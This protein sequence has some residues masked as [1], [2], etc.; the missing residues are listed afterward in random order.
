MKHGVLSFLV[1]AGLLLGWSDVRADV[2]AYTS[3][4][5]G[6][7]PA[8]WHTSVQA[9]NDECGYISSTSL[10]ST[11]GSHPSRSCTTYGIGGD[12]VGHW[13][14]PSSCTLDAVQY[15]KLYCAS[16]FVAM[17]SGSKF[18]GCL[19]ACPAGYSGGTTG[20]CCPAGT[21]Y[22]PSTGQCGVP[23]PPPCEAGVVV[24]GHAADT[25]P[26]CL[27]GCSFA[28]SAPTV[29]F[30]GTV[31]AISGVHSRWIGA[32]SACSDG[33]TLVQGATC[34]EMT[35]GI[36]GGEDPNYRLIYCGIQAPCP[37]GTFAFAGLCATDTSN[38]A[39]VIIDGEEVC[40]EAEQNCVVVNGKRV[41]A[42]LPDPSATETYKDNGCVWSFAAGE[43]VC[44]TD[45]AKTE[46]SSTTTTVTDPVTGNTTKTTVTTQ[47]DNL[48]PG[49]TTTTTTTVYDS[50]GNELSSDS[51]SKSTGSGGQG[52]ALIV[53]APSALGDKLDLEWLRTAE[54]V[55]E[56]WE[57]RWAN[58]PVVAAL[59]SF[60]DLQ[61]VAGQ[62]VC[63]ELCLPLWGETLC[64]TAHCD[65]WED[66]SVVLQGVL[67]ALYGMTAMRIV[68]SA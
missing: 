4:S 54:D 57:T 58:A 53:R 67:L 2:W 29:S 28:I 9:H 13:W 3:D 14:P 68:L 63:P 1:L 62:G 39:C 20:I 23:P 61:L 52:A 66:I 25:N 56:E 50:E 64:T 36:T 5:S 30:F 12:T 32:G 65:I 6:G 19:A 24:P 49:F 44:P 21:E 27:G 35:E 55:K 45:I 10:Y 43:W 46:K 48:L 22:L 37:D 11:T 38:D 59:A 42:E 8:Y 18:T 51:V 41:C 47:K 40:A 16:P 34:A 15:Y 33:D 26:K 17:L 60:A 31:G 7:C